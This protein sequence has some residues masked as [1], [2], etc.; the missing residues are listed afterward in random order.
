M[1][2][3]GLLISH[4]IRAAH[5]SYSSQVE[6][7]AKG[8]FSP[9]PSKKEGTCFQFTKMAVECPSAGPLSVIFI[10]VSD[11]DPTTC[12][13]VY[14]LFIKMSHHLDNQQI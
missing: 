10:P 9:L 12:S 7:K 13:E 3:A 8:C 2:V 4:S 14:S 5:E 6:S 1:T 11:V